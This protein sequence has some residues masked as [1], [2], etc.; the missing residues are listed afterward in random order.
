MLTST[1]I[2]PTAHAKKR[3]RERW[4]LCWSEQDWQELK[5]HPTVETFIDHRMTQLT[6]E[7]RG[8]PMAIQRKGIDVYVST[9]FPPKG[10]RKPK[11]KTRTVS[12][13]SRKY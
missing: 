12:K 13:R 1:V 11:N 4:G 10:T 7:Y 3:L 8:V 5:R 9:V 6:I 2:R